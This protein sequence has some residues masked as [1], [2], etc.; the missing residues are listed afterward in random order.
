[1]KNGEVRNLRLLVRFRSNGFGDPN[2]EEKKSLKDEN[3]QVI[4]TDYAFIEFL[5]EVLACSS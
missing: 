2:A 3:F 1:L 4:G 5:K